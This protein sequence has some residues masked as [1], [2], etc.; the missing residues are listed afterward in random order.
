MAGQPKFKAAC[1]AI[2]AAGGI[3]MICERLRDGQFLTRIAR[4]LTKSLGMPIDRSLLYRYRN[5][6]PEYATLFEEARTQSGHSLVEDAG[7]IIDDADD[8][9]SAQVQK[10]KEQANF[11]KWLAGK[12]NR[13]AYGEQA[14]QVQHSFGA[15]FLDVLR[16]RGAPPTMRALRASDEE[17]N[18]ALDQEDE[19]NIEDAEFEEVIP[20]ME[21]LL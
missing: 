19:D 7:D 20:T 6:K 4:D 11:R 17:D 9:T 12:V 1:R 13:E 21:E 3:E 2:T 5:T 8:T 15:S 10:A 18:R 14:V 16:L